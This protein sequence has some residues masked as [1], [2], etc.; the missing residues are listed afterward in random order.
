MNLA[1]ALSVVG[2]TYFFPTI[3]ALK[4][5]AIKSRINEKDAVEIISQ[6]ISGTAELV[7]KTGKDPDELKLMTGTRTIDE[8]IVKDTFT[9]ALEE[10]FS[11]VNYATKK[12][13]E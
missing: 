7:R 11:K 5:F 13:T 9:K 2:P 1:T 10:A 8:E 4:D 12:L 6:T 3:K